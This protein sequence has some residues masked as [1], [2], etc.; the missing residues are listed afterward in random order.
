MAFR[1]VAT[2]GTVTTCA[3]ALRTRA[4]RS[5]SRNC[6]AETPSEGQQ[7]LPE[8]AGKAN[9]I[10]GVGGVVEVEHPVDDRSQLVRGEL[11]RDATAEILDQVALLL[12]GA[13]PE[14]GG[15][16][17]PAAAHQV[18][19]RERRLIAGAAPTIT[20]RPRKGE[21]ADAVGDV[22]GSDQLEDHICPAEAGADLNRAFVGQDTVGEAPAADEPKGATFTPA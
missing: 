1:L 9:L 11:G 19:K 6:L 17:V 15:D 10:Q 2:P 8:L 16:Y 21:R 7:E 4:P 14:R 3:A 5:D 12:K 20:I 18:T 13:A 22:A